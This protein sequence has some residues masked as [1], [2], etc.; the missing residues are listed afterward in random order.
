VL[1]H[2]ADAIDRDITH[3]AMGTVY[4]ESIVGGSTITPG[5]SPAVS[6][7]PDGLIT[8]LQPGVVD[9]TATNKGKTS[10]LRVNVI[11]SIDDQPL[12]EHREIKPIFSLSDK[13]GPLSSSNAQFYGGI[14]VND[15]TFTLNNNNVKR[16]EDIVT[17]SGRIIPE[18][19]HV[20]RKADIIVLG[21]YSDQPNEECNPQKGNWYVNT[22]AEN[23]YCAWISDDEATKK[24]CNDHNPTVRSNTVTDYWQKWSGNL[25][26]LLPL[27]TV[28]LSNTVMLTPE[29]DKVLYKDAP[30][31]TGHVCLNFGYRLHD[32]SCR[33]DEQDC[34]AQPDKDCTLVFNGQP[35]QFSVQE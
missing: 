3:S 9:I 33:A 31:Y 24:W 28:T 22:K 18:Q 8:G 21:L 13:T 2:F 16:S 27:Y 35:L 19:A 14:S 4:S 6:I 10:T 5:D 32:V 20:G 7:S 17:V 25:K 26:Q 15:G 12:F 23:L 34:C 29:E 11:F 30:P 1:G